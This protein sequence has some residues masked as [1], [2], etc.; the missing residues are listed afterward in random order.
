MNLRHLG[1]II[2]VVYHNAWANVAL[3]VFFKGPSLNVGRGHLS[4]LRRNNDSEVS[5]LGA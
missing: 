5:S 1:I 2:G 3:V 4:F